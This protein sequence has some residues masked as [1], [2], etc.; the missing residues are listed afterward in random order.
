MGILEN[1][2]KP[3]H[4]LVKRSNTNS[5]QNNRLKGHLGGKQ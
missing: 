3:S 2:R 5:V 4:A 1:L